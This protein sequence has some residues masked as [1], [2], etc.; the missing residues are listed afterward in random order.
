MP[1]LPSL[2]FLGGST[3]KYFNLP[4]VFLI[5]VIGYF[6][7]FYLN[8]TPST[9][10]AFLYAFVSLVWIV[11][12]STMWAYSIGYL[13]WAYTK[14]RLN[15]HIIVSSLSIWAVYAIWVGFATNGYLV[16]V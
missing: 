10:L 16:S 7:P 2:S 12:F 15:N 11:L 1:L 9:P 5:A 4:L 13:V 14:K 3:I 6:A 8:I